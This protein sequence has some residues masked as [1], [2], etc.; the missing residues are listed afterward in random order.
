MK[1]INDRLSKNHQNA[2]ERAYFI[3]FFLYFIVFFTHT[4]LM[5][6]LASDLF[7]CSTS[8]NYSF[9]SPISV[10][11]KSSLYFDMKSEAFSSSHL[12]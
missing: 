6:F 1:I 7:L 3:H 11:I 4:Q 12:N 5:I 8:T 2:N 10:S 9:I